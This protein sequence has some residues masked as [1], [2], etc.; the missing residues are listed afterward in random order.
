MRR[1][2]D[3]QLYTT[4]AGGLC[5]PCEYAQALS[6]LGFKLVSFVML[7]RLDR[8]L[9]RWYRREVEDH[10]LEYVVRVDLEVRSLSEAKRLLRRYRRG[11]DI[12]VARP[13]S[14]SA[15]RFAARDGRVDMVCF[16]ELSPRFDAVQA[17]MMG[18]R[19][20][21]VELAFRDLLASSDR[22][23]AIRSVGRTLALALECGVAVVLS[24]GAR[25]VYEVRAPRD[26]AAAISA[27]FGVG[28]DV[29]LKM[30]SDNPLSVVRRSKELREDV[31]PGLRVVGRGEAYEGS[32]TLLNFL[33]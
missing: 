32:E 18:E 28:R 30:V 26:M 12:I 20:K 10:G 13:R 16:D 23:A 11:A 1:F 2:A 7:N 21:A 22:V 6:P 25:S 33:G 9:A 17:R 3:L 31:L 29:A 24:S 5:T 8:R 19:G 4:E 15:A 14:L 27:L